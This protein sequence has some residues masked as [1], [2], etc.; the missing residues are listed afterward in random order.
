M[1]T[2]D[3]KTTAIMQRSW[4]SRKMMQQPAVA[5]SSSKAWSGSRSA[6]LLQEASSWS[7][8]QL[9]SM[10]DVSSVPSRVET[11]VAGDRYKVGPRLVQGGQ[12]ERERE[13]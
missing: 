5:L 6:L 4:P 3:K 7:W 8:S 13:R 12:K 11:V 1:L 2:V 10:V 9:T